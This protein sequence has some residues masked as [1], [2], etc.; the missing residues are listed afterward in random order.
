MDVRVP[1]GHEPLATAL[2]AN[3]AEGLVFVAAG[4]DLGDDWEA[5]AHELGEAFDASQAAMRDGRPIVYVVGG[6]DLL[7]QR[8]APPPPWWPAGCS[9]RP[10]PPPSKAPRRG[11]LSTCWQSFEDAE[12]TDVAAWARSVDRRCPRASVV[13]W[14]GC[15]TGH[16]GKALP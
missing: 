11:W 12:P 15:G 14:S 5:V 9:R 4:P 7:G 3:D 2:G 1:A 6:P 13:R 16:L 10:A 8:G